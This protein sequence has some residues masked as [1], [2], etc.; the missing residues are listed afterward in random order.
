MMTNILAACGLILVGTG[1]CLAAPADLRGQEEPPAASGDEAGIRRAALDY[2]EGALH[3][4]AN[5]VARGVHEELNKVQISVLPDGQRQVLLYNTASTL[6]SGV[7]A[8]EDGAPAAADKSVAVTV[9]DVHGDIAA[10]RAVGS[11]WYDLLHLA[12]IDGSWRIVNVLWAPRQADAESLTT[13]PATRG[14]IEAVA[15]DFIE[16]IYSG[17]AER[18]GRAIHPELHKVLL[19]NDARAPQP[20]LYK[21]GASSLLGATEGKMFLTPEPERQIAVEIFDICHDMASVKVTSAKFTDQLLLGRV[22]GEWKVVN[23]L[24]VANPEAFGE[25]G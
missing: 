22:N 2:M 15:L 8:G 20:F 25:G 13:D 14:E 16:G 18:V 23:D 1:A 17:D 12:R 19:R 4:D 7:Q 5:R 24:W 10:A 6:I 11:P 21:M 3:A 9:F